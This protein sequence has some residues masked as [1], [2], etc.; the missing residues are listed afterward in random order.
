M[1]VNHPHLGGLAD[2]AQ[3]RA[4]FHARQ[5]PDHGQDAPAAQLF[6]V[7]KRDVHGLGQAAA[8]HFRHPCQNRRDKAF[9]VG[10]AAPIQP[11]VGDPGFEGVLAPVLPVDRH[12][13]GVAGKDDPGNILRPQHRQQV[14]LGAFLVFEQAA[15]DTVALQVIL[16]EGDQMQVGIAADRGH[17]HKPLGQFQCAV[18]LARHG[19]RIGWRWRRIQHESNEKQV[20][21]QQQHILSFD[22]L[23]S[24]RSWA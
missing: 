17:R 16:H 2:N 22:R 1:G 10:G 24:W 14:C 4:C 13:I 18:C 12:H 7:G 5:M 9:H 6:V 23:P 11:V 20:T 8:L 19:R 21:D 3:P 15:G